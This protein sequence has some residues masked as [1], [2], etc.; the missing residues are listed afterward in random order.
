MT[1]EGSDILAS[2]IQAQA[3]D[4]QVNFSFL[5]KDF[6]KIFDMYIY[7]HGERSEATRMFVMLCTAPFVLFSLFGI[8]GDIELKD[9]TLIQVLEQF[10]GFMF[11]IFSVFGF[12]GI[13]PFHRFV[14]AHSNTYKMIR[15][16]NGYRLFYYQLIKDEI[17]VCRWRSAIEKDPRVPLPRLA[18]AHWTTGFAAAMFLLNTAYVCVGLWL[19]DGQSSNIL[20]W[21]LAI[22]MV[23]IHAVLAKE[24]LHADDV[25]RLSK[26]DLPVEEILKAVD[27]EVE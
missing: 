12:A 17:D 2:R 10:P 9:K 23:G 8:A 18:R 16:M 7:S 26:Q 24:E 22:I 6:E 11:L 25:D 20:M 14:A 4:R 1:Q 5:L 3:I 21:A 19:W 13:V 27:S 15:Y